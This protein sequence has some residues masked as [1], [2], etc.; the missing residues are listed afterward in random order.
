M[1][2]FPYHSIL[3]SLLLS[4]LQTPKSPSS[5]SP[6]LQLYPLG[7]PTWQS[8]RTQTVHSLLPFLLVSPL[9]GRS[10]WKPCSSSNSSLTFMSLTRSGRVCLCLHLN[11]FTLPCHCQMQVFSSFRLLKK[12]LHWAL[13]LFT[14]HLLCR[15]QKILS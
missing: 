13:S 1:S 10:C 12:V 15:C 9:V 8:F 7:I 3:G 11:S 6:E 2:V 4:I 14:I 5:P